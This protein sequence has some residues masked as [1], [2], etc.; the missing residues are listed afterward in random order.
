MSF[1]VD[2]DVRERLMKLDKHTVFVAAVVTKSLGRC[3]TCG[4]SW[5]HKKSKEVMDDHRTDA[6]TEKKTA[7]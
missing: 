7:S 2:P 6:P 3:P 1:A 4:G 5:P